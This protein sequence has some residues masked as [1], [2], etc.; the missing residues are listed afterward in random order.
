MIISCKNCITQFVVKDTAIPMSGRLVQCSICST[1]WVE[2][3][4]KKIAIKNRKVNF[5][6][7][8]YLF[9]FLFAVSLPTKTEDFD[10]TASVINLDKANNTLSA[11]GNVEVHDQIGNKITS[12]KMKYFKNED[13]IITYQN[14]KANLETGYEVTSDSFIYD[15][16]NKIVKSN[17]YSNLIDLD[18]NWMS[19]NSFEYSLIKKIFASKEDVQIVDRLENQYFLDE[20]YIDT[21]NKKIVGSNVKVNLNPAYVDEATEENEPRFVANNAVITKEKSIFEKGVFTLCKR[22][23][24]KCPPWSLKSKTI[25]HDK[26]KKTIYYDNSILRIYDIPV[27][28]FPKFFH[29]D[30]SV[31]RQSGLLQPAL[32]DSNI[33]GIGLTIPYFW[34]IAD[35]KDFTFTPKI[36]NKDNP[37]LLG[38]YRQVTKNSDLILDASYTPGYKN[39]SGTQTGGSRNH[40]FAKTNMDLD[41]DTFDEAKLFVNLQ[42]VSNDTYHRVHDINTIDRSGLVDPGDTTLDN[43][44]TLNLKK[45]NMYF[46]ITTKVYENLLDATHSR[47]EYIAPDISF[48]NLMYSSPSLG[49]LNWKT[50]SFYKNYNVDKKVSLMVNDVVWNSNK[51]ISKR[52]FVTEIEGVV[53][54][55]NYNSENTSEYK[56]QKTNHELNGLIS[57]TKSLP[58]E[59][60]DKKKIRTLSPKVMLRY[61]PGQM[62]NLSTDEINLTS[63]NL[64]SLNK[65]GHIDVLE[66]GT[67]AIVGFDYNIDNINLDGERNNRMSFSLGQAINL[68]EN[69][70]MSKSSSLNRKMSDVVGSLNFNFLSNSSL[71]YKFSV[72]NNLDSLNYNEISTKFNFGKISF[73]IDYLEENKHVGNENYINNGITLDFNESNSLSFKTRKNFQTNSTEFYNLNYQFKNDCLRAGIEFK[74]DFYSDRD[75]EPTDTLRFTLT[76]I[77]L[78]QIDSPSF[79]EF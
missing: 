73:N 71:D 16:I 48:G 63:N 2:V 40:M 57:F 76:I 59:K 58:M 39:P 66:T 47:Y 78:S 1:K 30:P 22:R 56:S 51:R 67:S 7:L 13:K 38:E 29:P 62:R 26:V 45:K 27:F 60:K 79:S 24:K 49:S 28:Y 32:T 37:V 55:T 5:S 21:E 33:V 4:C 18:G 20:M 74:R 44:I 43:E 42:R 23:G 46:D 35:N 19:V 75:V 17:E 9:F 6:L 50:R 31:K 65:T 64:F 10:I 25:T 52:G 14:S 77:P 36:Y 11:E 34:A 70:D 3:P 68:A 8:L 69:E 53:K 54:N 41:L 72:D 12:D 15:N 61:A